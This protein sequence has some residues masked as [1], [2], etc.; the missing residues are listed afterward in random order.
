MTSAADTVPLGITLATM[1]HR[2]CRV[3]CD[4]RPKLGG[5]VAGALI[6]GTGDIHIDGGRAGGI[7]PATGVRRAHEHTHQVWLWICRS[8]ADQGAVDAVVVGGDLYL[9][10]WPR[11]EAVEMIADGARILT[12][13]GIPLIVQDGNHEWISRPTGQRSPLE[14]LR[15]L[16]GVT[17]VTQPE[18]VTLTSGVQVACL[19]WPRRSELLE[20]GEGEGLTPEEIDHLVA[21]RAVEC[22]DRLAEQ[23]NPERGPVLLSAHAT[24]GDAV[25]G[26]SRRGSEMSLAEL[27]AEPVIPLAD[28]DRDPWQHVLLSHIHR[29]QPLGDR[30]WYV[31]SPDRL[32]FSDQG[33]DKAVSVLHIPDDGTI[34]SVDALPTPARQFATIV[35][36]D[37]CSGDDIAGL[38]PDTIAGT[39]V[40][41]ELPPGT[42]MALAA[43][44]RR[45]ADAAGAVVARIVAPPAARPVGTD[46]PTVD[47]DIGPLEGLTL[48]LAARGTAPKD[49]DRLK[50]R[51]AHLLDAAD[52]QATGPAVTPIA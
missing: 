34:A 18:V 49:A 27:F 19:P 5:F 45:V 11:A 44:A 33:V 36:P 16:P 2:R 15:D 13:A 47:N 29:R 22:I 46:R 50:A 30:C 6:V 4:D 20:P 51:A 52:P 38:F 3:V 42:D 8:A 23:V 9:N 26:S 43:H 12:A 21:D 32:D 7:N 48:W 1:L 41:L 35:V 39:V 10:G 24:V 40:K 25:V 17:V 37:G 31:G 28:I 14:H